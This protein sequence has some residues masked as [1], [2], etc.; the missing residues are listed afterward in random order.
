MWMRTRSWGGVRVGHGGCGT[1]KMRL[2]GWMTTGR[3]SATL[4]SEWVRGAVSAE[5]APVVVGGQGCQRRANLALLHSRP[6][7]HAAP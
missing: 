2:S 5:V 4:P 1:G 3:R 6:A 7:G